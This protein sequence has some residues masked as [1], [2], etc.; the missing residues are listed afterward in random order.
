MK[1]AFFRTVIL[2]QGGAMICSLVGF[3]GLGLLCDL[4]SKFGL[5]LEFAGDK[6]NLVAA[7]FAGCLIGSLLGIVLVDKFIFGTFDWNF[8]AIGFGCVMGIVAAIVVLCTLWRLGSP[9]LIVLPLL[10]ACGVYGG[11][12]LGLISAAHWKK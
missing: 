2:E 3:W 7:S 8:K 9:L 6:S 5:E 1:S 10:V 12:R 11:Y 4:C